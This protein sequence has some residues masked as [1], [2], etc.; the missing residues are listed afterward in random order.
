LALSYLYP[1]GPLF[2]WTNRQTFEVKSRL[3]CFL[4]SPSWINIFPHTAIQHLSDNGSDH[5][6]ILLTSD[7]NKYGPK[8]YFSFDSRWIS[9]VEADSIISNSWRSSNPKGSK[10]F[11]FHSKL[12]D[13]R[14]N[15]VEWQKS[16]RTNSARKIIFLKDEINRIKLGTS[17]NW[18]LIR[19]LESKLEQELRLEDSYWK[20]KARNQWLLQGDRNTKYFHRIASFNRNKMHI[21][22]LKDDKGDVLTSEEDKQQLAINYFKRLFS[23]DIPP[24]FFPG[25]LCPSLSKSVSNVQNAALIRPVTSQ[26]IKQAVFSLGPNQAPGSDGFTSTFYRAFWNHIH[27]DL[28]AAV[29]SFFVTGSLPCNINH[30]LIS[31]I[32]KI[33]NPSSMSHLRP[34]SLCQFL[35]KII[36]KILANRLSL[37]LPSIIG[38]HQT[39]FV[40]DRRITDNIII[41]HELMHFL[42]RKTNGTSHYLALKLDMEK[43]YDR[44]EWGF[45]F[46]MLRRLGFHRSFITWVQACITSVSYSVNF[47][48][49]R[50]GFFKP[51]RGLRQGDP[52]SP[53]L[54][55]IVSE[56]LS[57][58]FK[59]QLRQG[60]LKGIKIARTAPVISHLFFADDTFLFLKIDADSISSLKKLFDRYQLIS[61]QKINFN[62]SAVYFSHN[63]PQP[64]QDF[65]GRILGVKNIGHQDKYLGIPSIVPRSKKTMFRDLEDKLRKKLAGSKNACLS[66]AGKEILIKSVISAFPSYMKNCFF[67]SSSLCKKFNSIVS[68]FW[69]SNKDGSKPIHWVSWKTLTKSKS[70]GGL[71]FRDFRALNLALLAK[72]GWWLATSPNSLAAKVLKG[73]YFPSSSFLKAKNSCNGSWV[74]QSLLRGQELLLSGVTWQL[75]DGQSFNFLEDNWLFDQNPFKPII[76]TSAPSMSLTLTILWP[77]AGGIGIA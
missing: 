70:Q 17:T 41:A 34:I 24:D 29:R 35:Y 15:L 27:H 57:A 30:T 48:G 5:R 61:G 43:A 2:T 31:L 59:D 14:H 50:V 64:L 3:D 63:T 36:A 4:L 69:W 51:S 38:S 46:E 16:G 26:E 6:A 55:A 54:F 13:L 20:T 52:L 21:A 9:N 77:E 23:S 49:R 12:K 76:K 71:D 22:K 74:W 66:A 68:R 75:G 45:L 10:L 18:D 44:I 19:N 73:K 7:K 67:L 65:Y 62:K 11:M 25:H 40:R 33:N 32:P 39:G 37:V 1:T 28:C 72:Q 58:L 8:K 53:L 42:K 56:G 60:C 47:N